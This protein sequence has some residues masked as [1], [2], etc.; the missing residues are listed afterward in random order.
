[1]PIFQKNVLLRIS[2]YEYYCLNEDCGVTSFVEDYDGFIKKSG[3]MTERL[4]AFILNAVDT[5]LPDSVK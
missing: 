5:A 1:L 4:E 3:R 2:A